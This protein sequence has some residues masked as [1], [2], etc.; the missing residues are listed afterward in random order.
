MIFQ[1]TWQ[2]I[3][4]DKQTATRRLI[5]P[6]EK[7]LDN[8]RRLEVNGRTKWQVG[9]SYAIQPGRK[10]KSVGRIQ[11]TGIKKELLGQMTADDAHAEGFASLDDFQQTWVEIHGHYDP[12]L[13]VWVITL[14]KEAT[15]EEKA[16]ARRMVQ[17]KLLKQIVH[18]QQ[19]K[20]TAVGHE[21]SEWRATEDLKVEAQCTRC[22]GTVTV[23]VG[24]MNLIG[25]FPLMNAERCLADYPAQM[26]AANEEIQATLGRVYA[27]LLAKDWDK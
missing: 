5:N 11:I 10:K 9:R 22:K 4:D 25:Y 17:E 7:L 14:A 13:P 20:L 6:G 26:E 8:P 27:I 18:E 21:L 24:E 19:E 15:L 12:D 2:L 16:K 3:L 23:G 1:Y